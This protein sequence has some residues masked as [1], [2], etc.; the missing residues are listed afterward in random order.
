MK[1]L[2]A[3]PVVH[4]IGETLPDIIHI[5][6]GDVFSLA[7]K[8]NRA[9]KKAKEGG[10]DWLCWRHDD[11][12]I[13]TPELV[14]PQ[15]DLAYRNGARVCGVIGS[16]IC[17][18]SR[19]WVH[20]RPVLTAGGI[21]QGDGKGGFYPMIDCAGFNPNM[22]LLDGCCMWIH[23]DLFDVRV[24]DYCARHL[25]DD[26][27]CFSSLARGY[28]VAVLDVRCAHVSQGGYDMS[29]YGA[30]QKKFYEEWKPR[31]EFPVIAQSKFNQEKTC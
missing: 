8:M 9:F 31:V 17:S 14:E 5:P 20:K 4:P 1:I 12:S 6:N 26:Y 2:T 3:V 19:W 24:P 23:K 22:V 15:L 7:D 28:K 13:E 27:I 29:E 21:M 25:Y 10:Y 16:L 11:L 30:A 18:D